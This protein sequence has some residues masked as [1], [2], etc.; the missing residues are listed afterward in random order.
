MDDTERLRDIER[1]LDIGRGSIKNMRKHFQG[2]REILEMLKE[3]E[4]LLH[5]FGLAEVSIVHLKRRVDR[6]ELPS[7]A[8]NMI[9]KGLAS[10][11]ASLQDQIETTSWVITQMIMG[12]TTGVVV[13]A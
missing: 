12:K 8:A 9:G 7:F 13:T 4:K 5:D 2:H 6:N 3:Q 11:S 10:H 1:L